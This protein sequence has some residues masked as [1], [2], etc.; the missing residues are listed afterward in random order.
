[1]RVKFNDVNNSVVAASLHDDVFRH[2]WDDDLVVPFISYTKTKDRRK[3][4]EW[5]NKYPLMIQFKQD[6][7]DDLF[8]GLNKDFQPV[9]KPFIKTEVSYATRLYRYIG[10]RVLDSGL[11]SPVYAIDSPRG[12]YSA[13]KVIKEYGLDK[14]VIE[15]NNTDSVTQEQIDYLVNHQ[16]LHGL[17]DDKIVYDYRNFTAVPTENMQIELFRDEMNVSEVE[18]IVGTTPIDE[19]IDVYPFKPDDAATKFSTAS[20]EVQAAVDAAGITDF[21]IDKVDPR[22]LKELQDKYKH[23]KR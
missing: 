21:T 23:C 8:L 17:I 2:L 13:G 15:E 9:Y 10:Y 19:E 20:P 4:P 1:M 12:Y 3:P 16:E 5:E 14:S 22:V 6:A 18:Q 7:I 11:I